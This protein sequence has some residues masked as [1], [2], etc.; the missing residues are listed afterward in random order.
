MRA[1]CL[2]VLLVL[3]SS[4]AQAERVFVASLVAGVGADDGVV[5]LLDEQ[6]L[7]SARRHPAFEVVGARDVRALLDMEENKQQVGVCDEVTCLAEIAGALDAPQLVTGQ[8]GRL[9]N[10]WILTL[11]RTER[12]TLT[13]LVRVSRETQGETPEGLLRQIDGQV[14][15]LFGVTAGPSPLL[16]AGGV[17]VGAGVVGLGVGLYAGYTSFLLFED[18]AGKLRADDPDAQDVKATAQRDGPLFNTVAIV[19][20]VAGAVLL[21]GG[22]AALIVELTE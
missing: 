17:G 22:G 6:I 13:A 1:Q 14:D 5:R 18:A 16:V 10:T 9:G 4:T 8:L 2:F 20:V 12:S 11:T 15:E 21:L 3:S 7:T 19:G